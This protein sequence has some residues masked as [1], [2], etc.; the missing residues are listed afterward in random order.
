M[1]TFYKI[2][3]NWQEKD[4]SV[5][6]INILKRWL[7]HIIHYQIPKES[8]QESLSK[9]INASPPKNPEQLN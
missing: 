7:K 3:K 9:H 6:N 4:L 8:R 1:I 5:P 2:H